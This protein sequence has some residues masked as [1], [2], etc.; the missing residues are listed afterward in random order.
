MIITNQ[1]IKEIDYESLTPEQKWQ[2]DWHRKHSRQTKPARTKICG[3]FAPYDDNLGRL[4]MDKT[5]DTFKPQ[6]T[7]G[8]RENSK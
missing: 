5:A 4:T 1:N 3:G 6:Q 8:A 2:V 7:S